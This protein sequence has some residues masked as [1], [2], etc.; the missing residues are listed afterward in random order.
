MSIRKKILRPNLRTGKPEYL[1]VPK[2]QSIGTLWT[3]M[4]SYNNRG[5]N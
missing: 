3:D 5:Q 1:V 2:K 4:V